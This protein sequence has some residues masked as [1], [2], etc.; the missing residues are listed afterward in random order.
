[1]LARFCKICRSRCATILGRS[2]REQATQ[3]L[4]SLVRSADDQGFRVLVVP[5]LLSYG[6]IKNGIRKRLEGLDHVMSP[7]GLLP[8]PRLADWVRASARAAA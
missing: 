5:A 7:A 6:G 3:R 4:R 8:D 1:M 2:V